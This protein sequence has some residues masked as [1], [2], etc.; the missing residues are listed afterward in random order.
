MITFLT[1]NPSYHEIKPIII[2]GNRDKYVNNILYINTK[3]IENDKIEKF[4]KVKFTEWAITFNPFNTTFFVWIDKNQNTS[5]NISL[6]FT[7]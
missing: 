5:D 2:F 4:D 1:F 6:Q 3:H 7:S